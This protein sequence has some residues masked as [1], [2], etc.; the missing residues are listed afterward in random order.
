MKEKE[1]RG[2]FFTSES[3][4]EGHPDKIC[5]IVS[6][7]ILD[8]ILKQD[9][10]ARVACETFVSNGLLV[11]GGEITTKAQIN[12]REIIKNAIKNIGYTDSK[13]GFDYKTCAII[14]T[15]NEQSP[16]IAQGVDTG[17]AGDQGLMIGFACKE[18][19]ELMPLPIMLAHELALRLAE[20]RK[21]NILKYLGPD[22]KTQVTVEY[23]DWKP[24]RVDTVVLST[25]HTAEILDKTGNRITKK[26]KQEI[27][28]KVIKPVLGNLID[29]NTV[30]HIN[31]T[32]KFIVGGPQAD[33][34]LTG[35]KIIVDTYGGM[36]AHGG[37]AFS[38]KDSTKV[39]RSACYMARHI[40]KNIVASGIAEKCTVQLA[41][42]IGVAEPVSVMVDT[43]H[44][45][46]VAG[47]LLEPIVRKLFPLTP[48]GIIKYLD[49]R[50]PV[51]TKTAAY[52][53]FGRKDFKWEQTNKADEI[54]KLTKNLI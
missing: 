31:P 11:V 41:Y 16:D 37:G 39:D 5:D 44:S 48:D 33:T 13:F 20:V 2:W 22:G 1:E 12:K 28:D 32:G 51:F 43:H 38:G 25:Q 19:K 36:A 21:K 47:N 23:R 6:D 46:K 4:T 10:K 34:G 45:G 54:K 53:H 40:A 29:K 42:A 27:F 7:S 26:A 52:G 14:D 3:V 50:K 24:Y 8:A 30:I 17:G 18:T 35:R 15:I 49:L 9:D